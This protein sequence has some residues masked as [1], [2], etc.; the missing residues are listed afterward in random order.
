VVGY[1]REDLQMWAGLIARSMTMVG[2]SS[3]DVAHISFGY[4]LFTG[5]MGVHYGAERLGAMVVPASGGNTAKQVMLMQDF[6]ATMLACTPSYALYLA[7]TAEK[8]GI[9]LINSSLKIGIFGAEP[10]SEKMRKQLEARLGIKA[11][12]IYGLSEVMGPGVASECVCQ[13]GMHVHE[14][15]FIVEVIDPVTGKSLPPGQKGELVFT[16]LTK[17]AF[18]VIRYRTRDLTSIIEEPCE[19]GRTLRRIKRIY[20]RSDDMLIIRG[21]NVFPSQVESVLLEFGETQPYYLLVVDRHDNLDTLEIQVEVTDNFFNDKVRYISE[22]EGRLKARL[23][24][25]LGISAKIKLVEPNTLPRTSGKSIRVQ[26]NRK[27]D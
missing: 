12:D 18:P 15:N 21:V 17:E 8:M 4:G 16:S 1:T 24:S 14:D 10:W 13:N 23:A 27:I 11:Y 9:D 20:G 22:L 7:E 19:C 5:G 26:D 2:G 6:K 3:Q 25:V